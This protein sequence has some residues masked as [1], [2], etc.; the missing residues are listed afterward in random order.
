[1]L[2]DVLEQT[3]RFQ[4]S[5]GHSTSAQESGR[6]PTCPEWKI[7]PVSSF[8]RSFKSFSPTVHVSNLSN[9]P[10][11]HVGQDPSGQGD[12]QQCPSDKEG[13]KPSSPRCKLSDVSFPPNVSSPTTSPQES[14]TWLTAAKARQR[15]KS[16]QKESQRC[17]PSPPKG[18]MQSAS[19]KVQASEVCDLKCHHE[20]LIKILCQGI[21]IFLLLHSSSTTFKIKDSSSQVQKWQNSKQES[22]AVAPSCRNH[23]V[24]AEFSGVSGSILDQ[25]GQQGSS[26]PSSLN[27][28]KIS[29]DENA[30]RTKHYKAIYASMPSLSGSR[31]R[32]LCHTGCHLNIGDLEA[33]STVTHF[34]QQGH[35][36]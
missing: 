8:R 17:T 20:D 23:Q 22:A 11:K 28:L 33:T 24:C 27:E 16:S 1:M 19:S 26:H 14:S 32:R 30:R 13:P 29:K 12:V 3:K 2:T 21:K 10:P 5:M 18:P 25:Q 7:I 34:L 6:P 36:S 9:S 35:T 15:A 31:R 4:E